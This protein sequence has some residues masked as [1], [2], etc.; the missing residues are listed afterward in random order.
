MA[1]APFK[2]PLPIIAAVWLVFAGVLYY[3]AGFKPIVDALGSSKESTLDYFNRTGVS[4]TI[5]AAVLGIVIYIAMRVRTRMQ[6][7]DTAMMFRGV[8]PD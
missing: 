1:N 5:G 6:G 7:V 3:F 8:P 2:G 4:F